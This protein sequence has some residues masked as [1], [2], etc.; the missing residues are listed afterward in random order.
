MPTVQSFINYRHVFEQFSWHSEE[1]L[2]Q[3]SCA[4]QFTCST[5]Q[6]PLCLSSFGS[7]ALASNLYMVSKGEPEPHGVPH[8]STTERHFIQSCLYTVH[9]QHAW[10][11]IH[12]AIWLHIWSI[13]CNMSITKSHGHACML[14]T[15]CHIE[16]NYFLFHVTRLNRM[17]P[18]RNVYSGLKAMHM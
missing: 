9:Q 16:W 7:A 8:K 13:N 4:L 15:M 1:P 11:L 2:F 10:T 18:S 17:H 14:H 6:T 12:N 3:V 5:M